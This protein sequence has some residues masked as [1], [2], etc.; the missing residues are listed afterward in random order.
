MNIEQ[1]KEDIDLLEGSLIQLAV[2]ST[3][4]S[5][6]E[7][8]KYLK[9]IVTEEFDNNDELTVLFIL[10]ENALDTLEWQIRD[11]KPFN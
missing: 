8:K 4:G 2:D 6:I 9:E 5:Y 1:I 10:A 3:D 7:I 11:I